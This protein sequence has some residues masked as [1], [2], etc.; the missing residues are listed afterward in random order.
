MGAGFNVDPFGGRGHRPS[1]PN[2]Q[3]SIIQRCWRLGI[4]I[5][6]L[7]SLTAC[8][9]MNNKRVFVS[10][11]SRY[12]EEQPNIS[13]SGRFLVF[14][15][16][17]GGQRNILL[18]DLQL[19]QFI[20]LPRFNRR[21]AIAENPSISNNARYIVYIASDSG[22]PELELYDR[23]RG[24]AQILTLG[25]RGWFRNPSISPDGRYIVFESSRNGQWDIEVID[26]GPNI[27]LDILDSKL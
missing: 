1:A 7:A 3:V 15:S 6:L 17:R 23:V 8:S 10:L 16:N 24:Q 19:R 21:D 18:Y 25:Y 12:N 9:S 13:G 27:E 5:F 14:V 26:R 2:T 4:S 11:N 22:K 20:D